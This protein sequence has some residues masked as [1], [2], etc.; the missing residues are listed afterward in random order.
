MFSASRR[1]RRVSLAIVIAAYAIVVAFTAAM[2]THVVWRASAALLSY[3][4][5]AAEA[6]PARDVAAGTRAARAAMSVPPAAQQSVRSEATMTPLADQ[7]DGRWGGTYGRPQPRVWGS[8][9][10]P[11]GSS[12]RNPNRRY[13]GE[14]GLFGSDDEERRPAGTFRTCPAVMDIFH[15]AN[16]RGQVLIE[17]CNLSGWGTMGNCWPPPRHRRQACRQPI[18]LRSSKARPSVSPLSPGPGLTRFA[19]AY[20]LAESARKGSGAGGAAGQ[21]EGERQG[22]CGCP[23]GEACA[24]SLA[25]ARVRAWIGGIRQGE[26]ARREDGNYMARQR[27]H[28]RP[29][30]L[31]KSRPDPD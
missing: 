22:G 6:P 13:D 7:W 27:R 21:A 14:D 11:F 24:A 17:S 26:I 31:L 16:C 2:T 3:L 10:S 28:A 23:V 1:P 19:T 25:T 18:P 15:F 5:P 9:A 4:A 29:T 30:A 20:A 8:A 12:S